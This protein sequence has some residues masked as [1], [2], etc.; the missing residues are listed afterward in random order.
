MET[1][2]IVFGKSDW[3]PNNQ[4]LPVVLYRGIFTCEDGCEEF[5]RLFASHGWEGLWRDGVFDYQHYHAGA[6]EVL[7][8]GKGTAKLLIGG[9]TGEVLELRPGDCIVL[10]A[11]TGHQN[12]GA[13][14][15]FE[16]VGA[17]PPGQRADIQTSAAT[18]DLLR[19]IAD[20]ALPETDPV[21]G[22]SGPVFEAWH[23]RG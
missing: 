20:V 14:S 4:T 3:V 1:Q 21:Q 12:L 17:Y 8:I 16:V 10:P 5:A 6:H 2:N 7:G 11:G 15:D 23:L 19:K 9:P 13:S 22:A 18:A